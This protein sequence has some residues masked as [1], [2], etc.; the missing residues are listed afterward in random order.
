MRI[1]H[2]VDCPMAPGVSWNGHRLELH[3]CTDAPANHPDL[4]PGIFDY[5]E[6]CIEGDP[7]YLI[8]VLEMWLATAKSLIAGR[9]GN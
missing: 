7:Q 9:D 3:A 8:S 6:I 4:P 1:V 2:D 5:E